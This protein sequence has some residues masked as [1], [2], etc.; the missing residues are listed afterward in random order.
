M[1]ATGGGVSSV[2]RGEEDSMRLFR[3]FWKNEGGAT[4]IEYAFICG[5]VSIGLVATFT[6]IGIQVNNKFPSISSAL[7]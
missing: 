1:F 6:R 7:G 3:R 2:S 4:A 5:I